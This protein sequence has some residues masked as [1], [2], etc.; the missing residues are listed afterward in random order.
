MGSGFRTA[1]SSSRSCPTS[2]L[3]ANESQLSVPRGGTASTGVTIRR[4][5]FSG[6][7]TVT[8]AD[9]PPGISVRPGSIAAGQKTGA[10]TL[11][12]GADASFPPTPIKL[13]G[14]A[15][16]TEGPFERLASK[17]VVYAQQNN[18][19][20]VQHRPLRPDRGAGPGTAGAL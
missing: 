16:R 1:L 15:Q 5:G 17:Q 3:L 4:K 6:P 11:S 14:R 7:I 10:L 8:V 2:S 9:P 13:V 18:V 12:A 20:D 19:P